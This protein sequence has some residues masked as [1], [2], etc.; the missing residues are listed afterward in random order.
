MCD[1]DIKTNPKSQTPKILPFRDRAPGIEIPGSA[2]VYALMQLSNKA[3][4][5]MCCLKYV[6]YKL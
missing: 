1:G 3:I 6:N 4:L 5:P 2:T